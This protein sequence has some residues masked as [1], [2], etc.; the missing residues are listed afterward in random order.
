APAVLRRVDEPVHEQ[1]ETAGNGDRTCEVI[2]LVRVLVL[3]LG[4]EPERGEEG[5]DADRYVDEEDPAPGER[6]GQRAAEHQA[7]RRAADRRPDRECPGPLLPLVERRRD[8]RG[9]RRRDERCAEALERA[10]AD[11][12]PRSLRDPV[13]ERRCGEDDEA[14]QEEP[15]P[16]QKVASAAAEQ[17]KA[18]EDERVRVDHPLEARLAEAEPALDVG[19][20]DIH[21]RRVEDDHELRQ[22][23]D[24]EYDPG[25]RGMATHST[26]YDLV[27]G[28]YSPFEASSGP[29]SYA[30]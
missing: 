7:D 26:P 5:E 20:R 12:H 8:D 23:D 18:G 1:H 22:A 10:E 6:L 11:Q 15:L 29:S 21:D 16:S 19:Q 14:D 30:T 3:R 25:I 24:Y 9:R 17:E 28:L 4:H 27:N 13:Q 2:A